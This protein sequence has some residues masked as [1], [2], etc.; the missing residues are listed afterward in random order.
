MNANQK[1]GLS[2]PVST[3]ENLER[4]LKASIVDTVTAA[5]PQESGSFAQERT[6]RGAEEGGGCKVGDMQV[7]RKRLKED[8][9][10]EEE[11]KE[12]RETEE[13]GKDE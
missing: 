10:T 3:L 1:L 9:E 11:G 13:E 12:D 2:C 8:G 4:D 7:E 5:G 6:E